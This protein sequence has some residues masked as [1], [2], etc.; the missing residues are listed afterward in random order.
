MGTAMGTKGTTPALT[1]EPRYMYLKKKKKVKLHYNDLGTQTCMYTRIKRI[2][3]NNNPP[4][5]VSMLLTSDATPKD[6]L[7][8]A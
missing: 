3:K 1:M 2:K 8:L 4:V 7:W 5:K 6:G